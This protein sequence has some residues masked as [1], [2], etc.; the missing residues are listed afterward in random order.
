M[1]VECASCPFDTPWW[2]FL[3]ES[4]GLRAVPEPE[5]LTDVSFGGYHAATNGERL[6][7]PLPHQQFPD[8]M[9]QAYR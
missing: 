3:E 4:L 9:Q 1:V 5:A 7:Y 6:T 2:A 8:T